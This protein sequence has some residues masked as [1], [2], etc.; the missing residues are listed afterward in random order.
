MLSWR[1]S[2]ALS[3]ELLSLSSFE[4]GR[5]KPA[6]VRPI[7]ALAI[8]ALAI[9]DAFWVSFLEIKMGLD[10]LWMGLF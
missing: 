2:G 5:G 9:A 7:E 1:C 10:G 4:I 3:T 8:E 6:L